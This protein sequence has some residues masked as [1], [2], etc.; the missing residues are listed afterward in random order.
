MHLALHL[1]LHLFLLPQAH[2]D[3]KPEHTWDQYIY[4]GNR[5]LTSK[6]ED[7][8]LL[9]EGRAAKKAKKG[10]ADLD[11]HGQGVLESYQRK[12]DDARRPPWAS[13]D[14]QEAITKMLQPTTGLAGVEGGKMLASY[15][16]LKKD[17]CVAIGNMGGPLAFLEA[18]LTH[19][20]ESDPPGNTSAETKLLQH[21]IT[22]A[23][24]LIPELAT[25]ASRTGPRTGARGPIF[26][27]PEVPRQP[28]F[29]QQAAPLIPTPA[30]AN[31]RRSQMY[32]AAIGPRPSV[33]TPKS[34]HST[35]CA[36][37]R[38]AP[39]AEDV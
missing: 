11:E 21:A 5:V 24:E 33:S 13:L 27:T 38:H 3:G 22:F 34:R 25:A 20:R 37:K 36:R 28:V 8:L 9:E 19:Y 35:Q 4:K 2:A 31:Q 39:H 23:N 15:I 18:N 10:M 1:A 32:T 14:A 29:A 17:D 7:Q 30:P 16:I 26:G 6:S 12:V